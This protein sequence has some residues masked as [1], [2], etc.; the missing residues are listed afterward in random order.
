MILV[1][2]G[3]NTELVGAYVAEKTGCVFTPG[4]YQAFAIINDTDKFCAG[5]VVSEYRGHDCQIS[6][7]TETSMAWRDDVVY[8]F[9]DYIFHQLKCV[10]CTAITKRTNKRLRGFVEALGFKLEGR[11]RLGFD[12]TKDALMYGLLASECKC[13][14]DAPDRIDGDA[15]IDPAAREPEP[16]V[17]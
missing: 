14:Q 3:D 5:I 11:M 1:P 6:C 17:Q 8:A 16:I 15:S 7:A 10:R 12:G 4:M 13:L 9:F 2:A